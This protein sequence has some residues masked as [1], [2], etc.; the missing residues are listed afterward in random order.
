MKYVLY[1]IA[2]DRRSGIPPLFFPRL[3]WLLVK[4][5]VP[6]KCVDTQFKFHSFKFSLSYVT[7]SVINLIS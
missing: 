2:V 5:G 1:I 6:L 4:G 7:V 3:S